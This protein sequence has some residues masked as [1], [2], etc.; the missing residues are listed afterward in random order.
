MR[1]AQENWQT[2]SRRFASLA[3]MTVLVH[4]RTERMIRSTHR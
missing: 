1:L 3:Q 4:L 2:Q